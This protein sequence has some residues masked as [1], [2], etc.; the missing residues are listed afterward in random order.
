MGRPERRGLCWVLLAAALAGAGCVRKEPLDMKVRADSPI[1]YALWLNQVHDSLGRESMDD[2]DEAIQEIRFKEMAE[3]KATGSDAVDGAMRAA[4]DGRTLRDVLRFGLGWELYRLEA[5]RAQLD[6]AMR[7]NAWMRI[8]KGDTDAAEYLNDLRRNQEAR[9]KEAT[10][11]T[12]V[13]RRKL[14]A[15][16]L[17]PSTP[18]A[19]EVEQAPPVQRTT[20]TPVPV[21]PP[22]DSAPQKL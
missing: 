19:T 20:P 18:P 2:L 16:D 10:A 14:A 15:L 4:I 6:A 13:L 5:E 1:A 3:G 11:K 22:E 7:E 17:S 21:Q 8:K 9:L 12:A